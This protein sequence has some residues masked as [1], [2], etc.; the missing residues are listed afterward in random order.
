[1][2]ALSVGQRADVLV[3]GDGA[4]GNTVPLRANIVGC[5]RSDGIA[6]EARAVI[7]Y[8]ANATSNVRPPGGSVFMNY[9]PAANS[10]PQSCANDPF[11]VTIPAYP[12]PVK[13]P[14]TT[15]TLNIQMKSNGTHMI[16]YFG[17]NSFRADYT[18]PNLLNKLA[19]WSNLNSVPSRNVLAFGSNSSIRAVIY[20]F[21][22]APHPIHL[23]GHNMQVLSS[24]FGTWDG[25]IIRPAN[26]QR[27]DVQTMFPGTASTPSYVVIQWDQDNPG[28]WPLHCH[29][30][31]HA[32]MGLFS[33]IEERP[34]DILNYAHQGTIPYLQNQCVMW[35][36]MVNGTKVLDY[37]IDSGV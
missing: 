27:R 20:N 23:H 14:A 7:A 8:Q 35:N 3:Y 12:I 4:V 29:F 19:G 31:L 16:Y 5:A 17:D 9:G 26:P 15:K 32:A 1:M 11:D 30:A 22:D 21:D 2:V 10:N 24:G 28:Y 6:D 18:T 36:Y 25:S 13:A 33:V 34:E 37:D